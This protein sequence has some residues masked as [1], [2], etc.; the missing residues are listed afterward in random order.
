M[1]EGTP[2]PASPPTT[3]GPSANTVDAGQASIRVLLGTQPG[4]DF[5]APHG[6]T[7]VDVGTSRVV[8]K[9]SADERVGVE[10]DGSRIRL[11]IG[12]RAAADWSTSPIMVSSIDGA[13]IV[14]GARSYRGVITLMP[15]ADQPRFVNELRVDDYLLGVVPQELGSRAPGD[16]AAAQAQAVAARSYAY[17]HLSP[18]GAYDLTD[19]TLDQVYGGVGAENPMATAAVRATRG[20][21]LEYDGRVVN[22]PY[23][24]TCGGTTAAASEVWKSGDEPYLRPVSDRIPGTDRYYCDISPRFAWTA[25]FTGASLDALLARY[26]ASYAQVPG[27]VAGAAQTVEIASRTPSGR[28]ATLLIQTDRGRYELHGNDIRYVLR[29]AGGALLNSTYF[30]VTSERASDGSLDRLTVTGRG[31]GHGIGMCQWGAIGRARAG[32]DF[33]TILAT[34]YPGTTLGW[35]P[36]R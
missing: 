14:V 32:Q 27:G 21:V 2:A 13:P 1:R 24:S 28:V 33:R 18:T 15:G 9:T 10:Q 26:L 34:Y 17:I 7:A 30:S 23:H 12:G 29:N 8:G 36:R 11:L 25:S 3:S 31:F 6:L 22:A 5:W 19:G 4:D 35:A 20:L 16:S